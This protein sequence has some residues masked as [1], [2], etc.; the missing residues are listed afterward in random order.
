MRIAVCEDDAAEREQLA[1]VLEACDPSMSVECFA[2]G[3]ALLGAAR[4]HAG[5]PENARAQSGVH[6]GAPFEQPFDIAFIDVYLER[7]NGVDVARDLRASFPEIAL[8]FVTSSREHAVEAF[9]LNALHYLVKPVTA[10]GVAEVLN[11]FGQ[12]FAKRRPAVAFS[13]GRESRTVYLDD[14]CCIQSFGHDKEL[15]LVDGRRM[16]VRQSMEE[17]EQTLGASFLKLNR[18]TIVNMEHIERMAPDFCLLRDGT[19]LDFARRERA[20]VRAAYDDYLFAHLSES[21]KGAG[22]A[23][24][25]HAGAGVAAGIGASASAP[26]SQGARL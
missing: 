15:L 14:I 5:A 18:G 16:R 2:D 11:R 8:V 3:A 4:V 10:E 26:G 25:A 21:G 7:E 20:N 1:R 13:L 6:T 19:R 24:G 12:S 23:E 9:S 17:L 22:G